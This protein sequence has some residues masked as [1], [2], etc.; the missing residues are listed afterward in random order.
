M[1]VYGESGTPSSNGKGIATPP[2]ATGY[3]QPASRARRIHNLNPSNHLQRILIASQQKRDSVYESRFMINGR[4]RSHSNRYLV[5]ALSISM[6]FL[7]NWVL[8]IHTPAV[9]R[10][11]SVTTGSST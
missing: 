1:I 4:F 8:F 5:A 3:V 10:F 9:T 6:N 7:T 2:I 11:P